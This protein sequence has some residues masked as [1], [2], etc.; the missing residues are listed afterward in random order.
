MQALDITLIVVLVIAAL[1]YYAFLNGRKLWR[2]VQAAMGLAGDIETKVPEPF[3]KYPPL[4]AP[5]PGAPPFEKER[6]AAALQDL[7]RVHAERLRLRRAPQACSKPVGPIDVA[8]EP[9]A[10]K[11]G[12]HKGKLGTAQRNSRGR[13]TRLRIAK[14]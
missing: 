8:Q 14:Y 13:Q 4:P 11:S 3:S 9:Y 2:S 7:Q 1:E 12:H 10:I 5:E 6:R